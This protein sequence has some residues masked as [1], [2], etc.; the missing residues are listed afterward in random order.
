MV[1]SIVQLE[2][3]VSEVL[4]LLVCLKSEGSEPETAMPLMVSAVAPVLEKVTTFA[5]LLVPSSCVPKLMLVALDF[6][7][8][9]ITNAVSLT[10]AGL[11]GE[12]ATLRVA[13]CGV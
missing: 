1:T 6:A 3:A 12:S 11:P 2:P 5:A 8:G 9:S 10:A 13:D 7:P 4:Q